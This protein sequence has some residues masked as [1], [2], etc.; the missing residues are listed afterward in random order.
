M[1]NI[2]DYINETLV[3]EIDE[4]LVEE[5]SEEILKVIKEDQLDEGVLGSIVGGLT[6]LIAGSSVMKAVCKALGITQGPLYNLLTSKLICTA[7]GAVIG[8]NV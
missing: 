8:K 2:N 1:K 7:A 6:G 5:K 4:S 3:E